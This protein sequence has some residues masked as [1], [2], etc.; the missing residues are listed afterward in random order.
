MEFYLMKLRNRHIKLK[1]IIPLAVL[2]V[3]VSGLATI[4]AHAESTITLWHINTTGNGPK[5]IQDAVDR[6]MADNPGVKVVVS[7]IANDTYKDKIKVALGANSAPCIFP[8]WGGGPLAAYVKAGQVIDLTSQVATGN[9]KSRFLPA[10][11]SN[12]TFN[13]KIYGIPVENSS[14]AV[15][16]YSKPIFA[17]YKLTPPTTWDGLL[18]IVA[19]LKSKNVA[20]FTMG[21]KAKWPEIMWYDY[22]VDR[23]G[24]SS[25]FSSAALRTG[26]KFTD[27]AFIRAGQLLQGLVKAGGFIKGF[28]GI[29]YDT[30]GM[31]APLY[32]GKAA[33][34]LMGSWEYSSFLADGKAADFGFFPFPSVPGGAGDP[35]NVL[36]TVGDNFYSIS[37][38]CADKANAFKVIQYLIDD[39]S[40]K[41]RV[42]DG[43][44]PPVAGV[45]LT[46]PNAINLYAL[47]SKANGVQLWWDQY[48]PPDFAQLHLDQTQALFGLNQSP[49]GMAAL[50]EAEAAKL[51]GP[52]TK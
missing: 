21:G 46:D 3:A 33:M 15:I 17:K 50:Q 12:V 32:A 5:L 49:S 29:D 36:G 44:I 10:S 35:T 2:G 8:S 25:A 16:W 6:F 45:K 11:W 43:R 7:P 52:S 13:S 51:L 9:Y 4:P 19:T 24:G 30:A 42:A 31:R 27:P 22:L 41:A 23:V 1:S 14:L 20:P 34:E 37:S 18:K 39:T 47:L 40:V 38:T 28:N 26:G 48:L